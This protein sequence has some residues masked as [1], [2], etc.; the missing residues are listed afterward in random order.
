MITFLCLLIAVLLLALLVVAFVAF[1][2]SEK[3]NLPLAEWAAESHNRTLALADKL[4]LMA[5]NHAENLDRVGRLTPDMVDRLLNALEQD[6]RQLIIAL[7]SS[8][9]ADPARA[10]R[11]GLVEDTLAQSD[12]LDN[13][14]RHTRDSFMAQ[15]RGERER[16]EADYVDQETREV[17]QPVGMTS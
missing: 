2:H 1:V 14:L 7:L 8:N 4:V 11:F 17:I 6:R 5:T 15:M 12:P 16:G 9:S 13:E 3:R 10:Q